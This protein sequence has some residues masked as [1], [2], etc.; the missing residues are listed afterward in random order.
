QAPAAG[1]AQWQGSSLARWER[2]RDGEM[3]SP[4]SRARALSGVDPNGLTG[5]LHVVT[6]RMRPGYLR[7]NGVPYSGNAVL[8]ENFDRTSAPN[9][10]WIVV[11]SRLDDPT[12]LN[13]PFTLST[14]FR[15]EP[16]GAKWNPQPCGVDK[17]VR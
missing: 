2:I 16:D 6:T 1:G 11:T 10:E 4:T 3:L 9:G 12:Y 5:S 8:T 14:H 17:P 7:K 13:Q 15:K